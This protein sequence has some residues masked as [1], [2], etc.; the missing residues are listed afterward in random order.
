M[1]HFWGLGLGAESSL[2][3][4]LL[5]ECV[6]ALPPETKVGLCK[7]G[8][9]SGSRGSSTSTGHMADPW[10]R[11]IPCLSCFRLQF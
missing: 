9:A 4:E 8:T 5:S 11:V 10:D 7:H 1:L 3:S 6:D 2:R